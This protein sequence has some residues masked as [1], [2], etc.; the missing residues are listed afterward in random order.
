MMTLT[1]C[2]FD[3]MTKTFRSIEVSNPGAN[4]SIYLNGKFYTESQLDDLADDIRSAQYWLRDV[5]RRRAEETT[6]EL[7]ME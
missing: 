6:P 7:P 4:P 1:R 3:A 2:H 5:R